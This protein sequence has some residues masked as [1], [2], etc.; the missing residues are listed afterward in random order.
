MLAILKGTAARG[1]GEELPW[2]GGE[3]PPDENLSPANKRKLGMGLLARL[4]KSQLDSDLIHLF[5]GGKRRGRDINGEVKLTKPNPMLRRK[6]NV[7]LHR[8][9]LPI[10]SWPCPCKP[11]R[12]FPYSFML[13]LLREYKGSLNESPVVIWDD[14]VHCKGPRVGCLAPGRASLISHHDRSLL[15]GTTRSC[16]TIP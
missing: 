10:L 3:G 6:E 16:Q 13:D 1:L 11:A 4:L 7:G 9:A 12:Y 8:P 14:E 5:L 2:E 15:L